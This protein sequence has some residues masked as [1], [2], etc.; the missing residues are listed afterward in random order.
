MIHSEPDG[1]RTH[2]LCENP[3]KLKFGDKVLTYKVFHVIIAQTN[4]KDVPEDYCD[5]CVDLHIEDMFID[6]M[7]EA[8]P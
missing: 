5:R 2:F 8:L 3:D 6:I 1:G 4:P 7:K